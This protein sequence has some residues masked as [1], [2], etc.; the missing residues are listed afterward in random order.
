MVKAIMFATCGENVSNELRIQTYAQEQG[1]T[2]P[3]KSGALAIRETEWLTSEAERRMR[4]C[5]SKGIP[6][7]NMKILENTQHG[8][9]GLTEDPGPRETLLEDP[10][11]V[12][13]YIYIYI[14][15]EPRH[16]RPPASP[17]TTGTN[18]AV[19]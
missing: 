13:I 14:G 15:S 18:E 2:A 3:N 11:G 8:K 16:T 1:G 9:V 12:Y 10:R 19:S 7:T 6:L 17:P 5:I 4:S